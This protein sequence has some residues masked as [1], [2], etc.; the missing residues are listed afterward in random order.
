MQKLQVIRTA[1]GIALEVTIKC[2][3]LMCDVL[4]FTHFDFNYT[5]GVR[6]L[7][8]LFF[9][10]DQLIVPILCILMMSSMDCN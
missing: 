6:R 10:P 4:L 2:V 9:F 8:H 1:D 3:Q 7:Y 5:M